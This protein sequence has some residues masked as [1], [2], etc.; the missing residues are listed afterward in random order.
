MSQAWEGTDIKV[1]VNNNKIIIKG[2]FM[3]LLGIFIIPPW[4]IT[5][6]IPN[7]LRHAHVLN[8]MHKVA[9][10]SK[11]VGKVDI[12][13]CFKIVSRVLPRPLASYVLI[14]ILRTEYRRLT[15]VIMS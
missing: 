3:D 1:R 8:E 5:S 12:P 15:G 11:G 7:M 13:L 6:I 9:K 4:Q 10:A 14:G 2:F